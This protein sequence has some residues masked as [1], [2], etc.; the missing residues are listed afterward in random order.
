LR[1][2]KNS[3]RPPQTMSSKIDRITRKK[4]KRGKENQTVRILRRRGEG[5]VK[6]FGW[7]INFCMWEDLREGGLGVEKK[8]DPEEKEENVRGEGEDQVHR[9]ESVYV[10]KRRQEDPGQLSG[11]RRAT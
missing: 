2:R 3:K 5:G 6:A 8:R 4:A 7:K 10:A 11:K 1:I 9:L